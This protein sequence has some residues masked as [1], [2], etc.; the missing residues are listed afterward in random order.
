M[1]IVHA[2]D[3]AD[4]ALDEFIQLSPELTAL[5][6]WALTEWTARPLTIRPADLPLWTNRLCFFAEAS[7]LL[8]IG[9][10]AGL[11]AV[12]ALSLKPR[13]R[14]AAIESETAPMAG[15]LMQRITRI[16]PGRVQMVTGAIDRLLAINAVSQPDGF[17]RIRINT[18]ENFTACRVYLLEALR[19]C[20]PGG[21]I[22][23]ENCDATFINEAVVALFAS[24]MASVAQLQGW[25]HVPEQVVLQRASARH[26]QPPDPQEAPRVILVAAF[27][28]TSRA[29]WQLSRPSVA[30]YAKR[31]GA[32][33][34]ECTGDLPVAQRP[35]SK[36]VA[37]DRL[38]RDARVLLLDTDV[39]IRDGAPDLFKLVP[40]DAA[41][42]FLEG[43]WAD[44][45][46]DLRNALLWAGGVARKPYYG[47]TGV[48]MLPQH[49]VKRFG[50]SSI[51]DT[52]YI[53]TM[54]EQN[55]FN[56]VLHQL[57]FPVFNLSPLF[58]CMPAVT[59]DWQS[60]CYFI[61]FA[62][63]SLNTRH[64]KVWDDTLVDRVVQT[65]GAPTFGH[66]A[67]E[68][69]TSVTIRTERDL[70]AKELRVID[71]RNEARTKAGVV[72][73]LLA[74]SHVIA[75]SGLLLSRLGCYFLRLPASTGML[76]WGPYLQLPPGAYHLD[77]LLTEAAFR[78][79]F[80]AGCDLPDSAFFAP[81]PAP[82]NAPP[83]L[84]F[85]VTAQSR[86]AGPIIALTEFPVTD[87]KAHVQFTLHDTAT[88]VECHI[89]GNGQIFDLYGLRF[90]AE[91]GP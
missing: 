49:L 61:H 11:A 43:Q 75:S 16:F 40:E 12:V 68:P 5:P 15:A 20:A 80:L 25:Q 90:Y 19:M 44:R 83:V 6:D 67:Q 78:R 28:Q 47:N 57:G 76:V 84:S 72:D 39:V 29:E 63:G 33:L 2:L 38:D 4:R 64:S 46:K 53:D 22:L 3:A 50:L 31:V 21:L 48:F 88:G 74:A 32:E 58:N 27:G 66:P 62:G 55:Y 30:A 18:A 10:R 1:F 85:D 89:H 13:L 82:D 52:I 9:C 87:G 45:A 26:L 79:A 71:I 70:R 23:V 24:G 59:P 34:V 54:Y 37:I 35:L 42:L 91:A 17:D 60:E 77:I 73:Q 65:S 51:K 14:Y 81:E 69:A 86:P 7:A 36:M 41:A 56:A 8:E